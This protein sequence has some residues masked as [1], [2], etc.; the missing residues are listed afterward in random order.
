MAR[1]LSRC[2]VVFATRCTFGRV[3]GRIM[4]TAASLG[5][6]TRRSN[7]SCAI[8]HLHSIIPL[9]IMSSFLVYITC[10]NPCIATADGSEENPK[11]NGPNKDKDLGFSNV[12]KLHLLAGGSIDAEK[13]KENVPGQISLYIPGVGGQ[14]DNA[15]VRFINNYLLARLA[16]QKSPIQKW[17]EEIYEEGDQL[18]LTG[19]SRGASAAR[20]FAVDLNNKGLRL[21][22]G[23][24]VKEIP[25]ELLACFDTVSM[26]TSKGFLNPFLI[27]Q[28]FWELA[29]LCVQ[30]STVLGEKDGQLPPNVKFA[31]HNLSMDD[32]RAGTFTPV[33][34]DSTDEK[35]VTEA[36]FPGD[37][38]DVGGGWYHDGLS[39]GSGRYMQKFMEDAGL[40]FLTPEQVDAESLSVSGRPDLTYDTENL[41]LVPN[42]KDISHITHIFENQN[43]P[44]RTVSKNEA[45]ENGTVRIHE[46]FLERILSDAPMQRQ[47][48]EE[49]APY[50]HNPKLAKTKFVV[51]GDMNVELPEKTEQ[52]KK[53]LEDLKNAGWK[54]PKNE[55]L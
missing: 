12:L 20:K 17:L 14:S 23:K 2:P 21:A 47:S 31:V 11:H 27:F 32:I 8:L 30:S 45:L 35:R 9:C 39:N 48:G 54:V 26:Q 29:T 55:E 6:P 16:Q 10:M 38:A 5:V 50:E 13:P 51:V 19:F 4:Q 52:L 43:R 42:A 3:G 34:M 41:S 24:T 46:S 49:D 1:T 40:K 33:L 18:Y 7:Q 22:S 28:K 36:W 37:H 44:I 15:I 25:V 53:A